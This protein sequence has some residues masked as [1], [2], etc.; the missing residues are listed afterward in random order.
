MRAD[1]GPPVV[2]VTGWAGSGRST[3]LAEVRAVLRAEERVVTGVR[4][5]RDGVPV[6]VHDDGSPPPRGNGH[7]PVPFGPA[8]GAHD[9]P[10]VARRAAAA[11]AAWVTG[12]DAVVVVDDAQWMDADTV[13]VLEA[14][15]HRLTGTSVHYVCAIAMPGPEPLRA[16]G[17]PAL[18]RLR[19]RGLVAT[20][21]VPGLDAD[22]TAQVVRDTLGAVPTPELLTWVRG[23][24]RGLTA[25]VAG[26]AETLRHTD[27]VRLVSGHAYLVP[28]A[29]A[30]PGPDT[31]AALQE[32]VRRL[33]PRIW[34]TATVAAALQP[35]GSALP[36]LLATA[37]ETTAE[38]A[39][40]RLAELRATGILHRRSTGRWQFIVPLL[41]AG[42]RAALGPY[43]RRVLA[44]LVVRAV[45]D[46]RATLDR[47]ALADLVVLAG[48]LLP[49]DRAYD[50]LIAAGS[51]AVPGV[52]PRRE[53]RWWA[54]AIELAGTAA[55]RLRARYE[56]IRA[57]ERAG[58]A[59]AS[60]AAIR[61]MLDDETIPHPTRHALYPVLVLGLHSAGDTA[62][63]DA[64]ATGPA[65]TL[66][67]VDDATRAICQV[68]ARALR[69]RWG[70][71]YALLNLTRPHWSA[72]PTTREM[73][74][75][76]EW[77]GDLFA[78]RVPATDAPSV[79][80][81]EPTV[82]DPARIRYRAQWAIAS[83]VAMGD[84]RGAREVVRRSG[85]AEAELVPQHRAV[86][87]LLE[88]RPEASELAQRA[89]ADPGSHMFEIGRASF[90]QQFTGLMVVRG[91]LTAARQTIASARGEVPVLSHL[92]DMVEG[93]IDLGLGDLATA[94]ARVEGAL[95][96][97]R[98]ESLLV[99]ADLLLCLLVQIDVICEDF[100]RARLRAGE[101]D[102]VAAVLGTPR[103]LLHASFGRAMAHADADET[104]ECLR[105]ARDTGQEFDG[106]QL[107]MRLARMG[108]V[109]ADEL[110]RIYAFYE[111]I[112]AP[113]A[114]YWTRT[115]MEISGVPVPGRSVTKAE[116][117]RLLGQLLTEG[118]TNRQI[119]HVLGS[120]EKSVEGR[121]GRLFS[122]T[123]YRSR[124]ELAA[125]LLE[126]TYDH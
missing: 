117:E 41:G 73:G 29:H 43:E 27:R 36:G 75:L 10:A 7:V 68:I 23:H 86:F 20:V 32:N 63:L 31:A 42:L 102:E 38:D 26:A 28:D 94:T 110:L 88:G 21:R 71:A 93:V 119:A 70:A 58:D 126:G 107:G 52:V 47:P 69:G 114:R 122:R 22:Q 103:A 74:E 16:V 40:D 50:E 125:A 34:R 6:G 109:E 92:L 124:I 57:A 98:G 12:R 25:V 115:A 3:V 37:L 24:S 83:L 77:V 51:E 113:L 4:L 104:A 39:C 76:I 60:L 112:D 99:G 54:A 95:D 116:N 19:A 72:E 87:A 59:D 79:L 33:G 65:P 84:V 89:I 97:A 80:D 90:Y 105:I 56:F 17:L 100:E 101:L 14:L 67:E 96:Q 5:T 111:R 85:L 1:D 62:E 123:G 49:A 44:T 82:L 11:T 30:E 66:W 118:L 48:R 9:D 121:L 15:A 2:L 18:E 53:E 46:G 55:E 64:I 8:A 106:A 45:W 78:G 61:E 81:G 13:A 91:Q 108:L 120:S 35:A